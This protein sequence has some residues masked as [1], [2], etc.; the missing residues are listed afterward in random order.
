M[1]KSSTS[2][3]STVSIVDGNGIKSALYTSIR[4]ILLGTYVDGFWGSVGG[5]WARSEGP[6][7]QSSIYNVRKSVDMARESPKAIP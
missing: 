5:V 7:A 6:N 4:S 1:T 3:S 2:H